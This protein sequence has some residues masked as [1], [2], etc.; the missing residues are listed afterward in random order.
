MN[1]ENMRT[2]IF[3]MHIDLTIFISMSLVYMHREECET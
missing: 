1:R 2:H 3:S